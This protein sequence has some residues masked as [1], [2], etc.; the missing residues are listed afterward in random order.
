[1]NRRSFF[2]LLSAVFGALRYKLAEEIEPKFESGVA[3][4]RY[5]RER[6]NYDYNRLYDQ[7]L[8]HFRELQ[9][10]NLGRSVTIIDP[11]GTR[12]EIKIAAGE[13]R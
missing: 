8:G 5:C 4:M 6:E 11:N 13:A 12:R 3:I 9:A 10:L 1:M 2:A 7:A